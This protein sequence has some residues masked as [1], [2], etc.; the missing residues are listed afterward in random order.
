MSYGERIRVFLVLFASTLV[1]LLGILATIIISG[2]FLSPVSYD[3]SKETI[4]TYYNL[5]KEDHN[6]L[7][8]VL[9]D[10]IINK[11]E[12]TDLQNLKLSNYNLGKIKIIS[13]TYREIEYS[14]G[15]I[16]KNTTLNNSISQKFGNMTMKIGI[17]MKRIFFKNR[18]KTCIDFS[19]ISFTEENMGFQFSCAN[20]NINTLRVFSSNEEGSGFIISTVLPIKNSSSKVLGFLQIISDAT[21]LEEKSAWDTV[22]YEV[23]TFAETQKPSVLRIKMNFFQ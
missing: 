2:L 18:E 7:S 11:K 22:K 8:K 20:N 19:Y 17:F 6:L 21:I 14:F 16:Y 23:S 10:Q 9:E 5:I 4:N 1:L 15:S 13:N 12:S 3:Y